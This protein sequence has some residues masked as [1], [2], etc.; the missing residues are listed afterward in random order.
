MWVVIITHPW[1]SLL[2]FHYFL[3]CTCNEGEFIVSINY[4]AASINNRLLMF[5]PRR[6]SSAAYT[7]NVDTADESLHGWNVLQS[8]VNWYCY[9]V[10]HNQLSYIEECSNA[11]LYDIIR[12]QYSM[13]CL[14]GRWYCSKLHSR[15]SCLWWMWPTFGE[16]ISCKREIA[17][18]EDLCVQWQ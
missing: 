14:N 18:T 1:P 16:H 3:A 12:M 13:I 7:Q 9:V 2:Y 15:L 11:S 10:A 6:L 8:V 17:N 4:I 5:Q